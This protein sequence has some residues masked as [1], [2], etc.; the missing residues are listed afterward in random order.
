M[1]QYTFKDLIKLLPN[2]YE[3][4]GDIN[5]I[6]FNKINSILLN[7]NIQFETSEIKKNYFYEWNIKK[8]ITNNFVKKKIVVSTFKHTH[9]SV[10]I[11][12]KGK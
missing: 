2:D 1:R 4:I 6:S 7:E 8:N 9:H 12:K 5:S 10:E 3:V 11:D